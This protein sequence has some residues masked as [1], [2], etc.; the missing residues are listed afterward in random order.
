MEEKNLKKETPVEDKVD[1]R[2]FV[3]RK[4]NALNQLDG[5]KAE[6]AMNRVLKANMG[7][8]A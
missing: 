5:A 4:L 6:R 1:V 3:N 8:Q 2:A 7:G